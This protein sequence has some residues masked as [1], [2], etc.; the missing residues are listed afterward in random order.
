M[1]ELEDRLARQ[2]E[3]LTE[4]RGEYFMRVGDLCRLAAQLQ[5]LSQRFQFTYGAVDTILDESRD[6]SVPA[7]VQSH[8][9]D[10][11]TGQIHNEA[12]VFDDGLARLAE[13]I[14]TLCDLARKGQIPA[15]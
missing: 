5:D 6:E 1:S 14:D 13:R 12:P 15:E 2:R 8:I 11:V 3:H 10:V 4:L 7:D 9:E